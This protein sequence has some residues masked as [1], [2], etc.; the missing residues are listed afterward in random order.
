[1][2]AIG[3]VMLLIACTIWTVLIKKTQSVNDIVV[4]PPNAP[5]P[6]GMEVSIGNGLY[7]AWAAFACLTISLVP[8]MI[9]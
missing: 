2:A 7:L 6:L 5:V 3:S 4:G 8:Y 9:M 1:M